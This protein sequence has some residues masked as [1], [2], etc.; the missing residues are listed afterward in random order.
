[1]VFP[2]FSI[3]EHIVLWRNKWSQYLPLGISSFRVRQRS[4]ATYGNY[5]IDKARSTS[6][7]EVCLSGLEV[8]LPRFSRCARVRGCQ[9]Q[10]LGFGPKVVRFHSRNAQLCSR[11]MKNVSV[12]STILALHVSE[13]H[14]S[15]MVPHVRCMIKSGQLVGCRKMIQT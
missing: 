9:L 5:G 2:N 15:S 4:R 11:A 3:L 12:R 14:H 8:W 13:A 7:H 1:M 6:S 10:P